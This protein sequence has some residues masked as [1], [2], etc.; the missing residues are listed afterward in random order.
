MFLLDLHITHLK[1]QYVQK[2]ISQKETL[3]RKASSVLLKGNGRNAACQLN[4]VLFAHL[5]IL[6]SHMF[7]SWFPPAETTALLST[8]STSMS[9]LTFL[10][11]DIIGKESLNYH[12]GSTFR[13]CFWGYYE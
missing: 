3:R 13:H 8:S 1:A 9:E 2:A 10:H 5:V 4:M 7:G 11:G 6:Q 12:P